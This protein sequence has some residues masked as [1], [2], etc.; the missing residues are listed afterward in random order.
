MSRA[1]AIGD[2]EMSGMAIDELWDAISALSDCDPYRAVFVDLFNRF[3][4]ELRRPFVAADYLNLIIRLAETGKQFA[5][6][7]NEADI[8][9]RSFSAWTA[10]E[11]DQICKE[12]ADSGEM[13]A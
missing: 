5:A 8:L 1:I 9:W 13:K 11:I 10:E 4:S 12:R 3:E 6:I 7:A 2:C